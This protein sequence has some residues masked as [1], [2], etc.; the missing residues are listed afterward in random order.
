MRYVTGFWLLIDGVSFNEVESTWKTYQTF[1]IVASEYY[2]SGG[3]EKE[4]GMGGRRNKWAKVA[5]QGRMISEKTNKDM[6]TGNKNYK[7]KKTQ[8]ASVR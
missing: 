7:P 4:K 3:K 5:V 1:V 8:K 2:A 6:Y